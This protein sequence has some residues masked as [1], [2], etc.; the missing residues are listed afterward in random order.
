MANT[1]PATGLRKASPDNY[2]EDMEVDERQA[3]NQLIHPEDGYTKDGTYWA[4]LPIGQRVSFVLSSDAAEARNE[5]SW[6]WNMFTNDPLKPVAYY[7]KNFV[8]PGAGLG[9]EG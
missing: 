9:L 5:A 7:F 2:S 8:L 6:L 3:F 1:A 4:D